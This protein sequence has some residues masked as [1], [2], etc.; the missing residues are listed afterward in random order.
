MLVELKENTVIK[1]DKVIQSVFYLLNTPREDICFEGTN[2]VEWKKAKKQ[3]NK[4][5]FKR[6]TEYRIAGQKEGKVKR[7]NM[8]NFIQR[9]IEGLF[10]NLY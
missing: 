5:F 4:D 7:Y 8:I 2:K 1:H 9:N 6:L 10:V 3:M